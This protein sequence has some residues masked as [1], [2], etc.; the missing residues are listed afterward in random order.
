[1]KATY[2]CKEVWDG[3]WLLASCGQDERRLQ[4]DRQDEQHM[5]VLDEFSREQADVYMPDVVSLKG[6]VLFF[7]FILSHTLNAVCSMYE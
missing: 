5:K 2:V 3:P 6:F 7:V 1:M 4:T